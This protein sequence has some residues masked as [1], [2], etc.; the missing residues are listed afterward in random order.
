MKDHYLGHVSESHRRR[1][2]YKKTFVSKRG[3]HNLR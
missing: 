3:Y 1:V 2:N